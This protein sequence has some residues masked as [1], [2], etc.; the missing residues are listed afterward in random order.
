M[1]SSIWFAFLFLRASAR[2]GVGCDEIFYYK[3]ICIRDAFSLKKQIK[4]SNRSRFTR[5]LSKTN[6]HI[7]QTTSTPPTPLY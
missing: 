2:S 6:Q 3:Y 7:L 1:T 5:F 4:T